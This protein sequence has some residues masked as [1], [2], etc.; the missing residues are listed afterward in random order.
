MT[1]KSIHQVMNEI[2]FD[3]DND[4]NGFNNQDLEDVSSCKN[5][6]WEYEPLCKEV[7][8]SLEVKEAYETI[9]LS[10]SI[11]LTYKPIIDSYVLFQHSSSS[12][13]LYALEPRKKFLY[14]HYHSKLCLVLCAENFH[15]ESILRTFIIKTHM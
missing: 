2:V 3:D 9:N 6:S 13:I 5:L 11:E 14:Q 15:I 4:F 10:S 12:Y 7:Q 1:E 8:E